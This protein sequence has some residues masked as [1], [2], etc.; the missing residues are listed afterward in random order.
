MVLVKMVQIVMP[1]VLVVEQYFQQEQILQQMEQ[2][3]LVLA[4]VVQLAVEQVEN[5]VPLQAFSLEPP[6]RLALIFGNEV[7]GVGQEAL[8][9]CDGSIEIP[10]GGM[11]H[12]LNI[13]VAAGIVLWE[14]VRGA[15]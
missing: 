4:V 1:M 3:I 13:S 5:S 11:K 6:G 9:L 15:V 14:L 12:S 8:A 7:G 2:Q 10:Q